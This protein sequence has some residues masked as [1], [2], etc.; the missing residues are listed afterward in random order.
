M[1]TRLFCFLATSVEWKVAHG[2]WVSCLYSLE[3][4]DNPLTIK[5]SK[6]GTRFIPKSWAHL[7]LLL[8]PEKGYALANPFA[9]LFTSLSSSVAQRYCSQ[10][11]SGNEY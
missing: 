9:G 5:I 8:S 4:L 7:L 11:R 10:Q 3:R 1:P 6:I 2:L